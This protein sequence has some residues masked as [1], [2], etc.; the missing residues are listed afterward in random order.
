MSP[1]GITDTETWGKEGERIKGA[2]GPP[3]K[4][5]LLDDCHVLG[6]GT[7][8]AFTDFKCHF[9]TF[10]KC[11]SSACAVDSTEV[12]EYIRTAVILLDKTIA[13]FFVKPFNA[14]CHQFV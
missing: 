14:A 11:A 13:F 6:L 12:Y 1:T 2:G 7:F 8:L 3:Q 4:K 9:L 10:E 5:K